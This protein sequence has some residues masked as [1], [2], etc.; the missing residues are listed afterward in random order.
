[1][2]ADPQMSDRISY[3]GG[4]NVS[5]DLTG[6]DPRFYRDNEIFTVFE[7]N[8]IHT[9]PIPVFKDSIKLYIFNE[10]DSGEISDPIGEVADGT[11]GWRAVEVDKEAMA[12]AYSLDTTGSFDRELV[13]QIEINILNQGDPRVQVC[14][15]SQRFY[16]DLYDMNKFDGVGPS[17]TPALGQYFLNELQE[18]K[19]IVATNLQNSFAVT[20]TVDHMLP[21][22]LTGTLP[23][24]YVCD[25]QHKVSTATGISTLM[26]GRGSFYAH[27]FKM[28]R[29]TV[30]TGTVQMANKRYNLENQ[31]IF[32]YQEVS[33]VGNTTSKI[34]TTK[35]VYLSEENYDNYLGM[36]GSFIDR[37]KLQM[38]V[39]DVDYRLTNL[40]V[41]KTEKSESEYGVYD[42]I[43]FLTAFNGDVLITYHAFGGAVV[44]EDVQDMRQDILN[45]MRILSS[46][47][48]LTSDIL[49]KQPV[50]RDILSR[51]QLME[52]YHNHFSRVEHAVYIGQEGFHWI[53]IAV[54]YNT[55]WDQSF[56]ITDEIGTFRVESKMRRWCYEF[57]LSVDLKKKLT[58]ALR[59]KTLATND[60]NPSTLKDYVAYITNRDDVAVRVCWVGDGTESGLMLQLGWNFDNYTGPVEGVD[61][62]TIV[63]TN[64]SGVTSKWR[65]IYSP[66]DNTYDAAKSPTK[67][68]K[69]AEDF[70]RTKNHVQ[71]I[72]TTDDEFTSGKK[73]FRF[74]PVY[75]YFRSAAT[76]VSTDTS[77]EY[78]ALLKDRFSQSEYVKVRLL[79]NYGIADYTNGSV[80]ATVIEDGTNYHIG[81]QVLCTNGIY[82]R[83]LYTS[84]PKEIPSS[85]YTAGETIEDREHVFEI[86]NDGAYSEDGTIEMP[87]AKIVWVENTST[88]YGNCYQLRQILEP[89]DGLLSWAGNVMLDFYNTRSVELS[90]FLQPYT[91]SILDLATIRGMTF[92]LYDRKFN[93]ILSR[94]VDL[95]FSGARYVSVQGGTAQS[96][97]AYFERLGN[98]SA[99]APYK[100]FR[101]TISVGANLV[102]GKH[103]V[104][105][106]NDAVIG[107]VIFDLMDLCGAEIKIRKNTLNDKITFIVA[108][109]VGTDSCIN[110]R[111]DIRQIDLHF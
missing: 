81:D 57:I 16:N 13:K 61:T 14:I 42:T 3:D 45:T 51:L 110:R 30:R 85:S 50:V 18:L 94:S 93:R 102:V 19:A 104:A 54:L 2:A 89:S 35:R 22:D 40:N 65:L 64:K 71:Y 15:K 41:A 38:L 111:Y 39:Q 62:D 8:Q 68:F 52:Q 97:I 107:Q 69:Y 101:S 44:F 105:E 49:D 86:S 31:A 108:P 48:L 10:N 58:E 55:S 24:N 70:G 4:R 56:P 109:Y 92:K 17:Y 96:G 12:K 77:R 28:W 73:Y 32:L 63:V 23:R 20:D 47:N 46:K 27:D 6:S 36:A 76:R 67:V 98:G 99:S 60:V 37:A 26:P 11:S 80:R 66:L 87:N 59:V 9:F 7:P 90:C 43:E 72:N 100:Y 103:F 75:T 79:P 88:T 25:E 74:E 95:G 82:E 1:M 21:E 83:A 53:N 106:Y 78:F 29:Y 33:T 5:Y 91:Q 84:V 34:T